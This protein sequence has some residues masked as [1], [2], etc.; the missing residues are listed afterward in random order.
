MCMIV[1][2]SLVTVSCGDDDD[3]GGSGNAPE[4]TITVN[5]TTENN[6]VHVF[7]GGKSY[8]YLAW[9]SSTNN[10][11]NAAMN[12]SVGQKLYSA[13]IISLGKKSGLGVINTNEVLESGWASKVACKP[14]Q[15]YITRCPNNNHGELDYCYTGIYV[16][17]NI[18]S[19]SGGIMGVEIQYCTFVPGKGWNQ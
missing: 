3:E 9:E 5:L 11:W 18:S 2:T 10:F 8:G 12:I 15:A 7:I 13:E 17:R 16:V 4:G 1:M 19:T 14:G 6:L